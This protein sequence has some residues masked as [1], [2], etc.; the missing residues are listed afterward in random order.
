MNKKDEVLQMARDALKRTADEGYNLP[1]QAIRE[2]LKAIDEALAEAPQAQPLPKDAIKM[3]QCT[4]CDH[5]HHEKPSSCDCFENPSNTYND[6]IALP[7][8]QVQLVPLTDEQIDKGQWD[9]GTSCSA[10]FK[11]GVLFAEAAHGI[12]VT[13]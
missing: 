8:A 2:A 6:W 4:G 11:A 7:A 9:D 5:L 12:G 1:G 13:K 10:D 3:Y